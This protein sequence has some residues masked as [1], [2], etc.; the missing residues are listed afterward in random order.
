MFVLA[1]AR[2]APWLWGQSF[3]LL[4]RIEPGRKF[5]NVRICLWGVRVLTFSSDLVKED[6]KG[7]LLFK[8]PP[9]VHRPDLNAHL[10]RPLY[11]LWPQMLLCL[12]GD[13]HCISTC[14]HALAKGAGISHC[15]DSTDRYTADAKPA[16]IPSI[17]RLA[18]KC[19]CDSYMHPAS[20]PAPKIATC[21]G[22]YVSYSAKCTH[23]PLFEGLCMITRRRGH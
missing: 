20:P 19:F 5:A 21:Q 2:A 14:E 7:A 22:S 15:F 1:Q 13:M 17:T 8:G 11:Q 9:H 18:L 16:P 6:V 12:Q 4:H 3:C 10:S 23:K